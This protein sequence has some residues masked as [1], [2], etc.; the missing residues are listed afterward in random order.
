MRQIR[1]AKQVQTEESKDLLQNKERRQ[2][3][4]PTNAEFGFSVS[5]VHKLNHAGNRTVALEGAWRQKICGCS[6]KL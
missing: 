5:G 3:V 4:D 2:D 1:V 6:P